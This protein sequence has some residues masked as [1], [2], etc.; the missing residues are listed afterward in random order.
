MG[1]GRFA[2][3]P[4]LPMMR[5]EGLL[6]VSDG[7]LIAS[8]HFLGYW[9]GAIIA[10]K[11]PLAP[12]TLLRATV[13]ICGVATLGMGLVEN[14][15]AI[16]GLRWVVGIC[17]AWVLVLVGNFIVRTLADAG[18]SD[19]QGIVFSGVGGGIALVGL[20]CLAFMVAG[21]DSVTSW[22]IAGMVSLVI[23]AVLCFALGPEFPLVRTKQTKRGDG[24]RP[25]IWPMLVSYGVAGMGYIIPATYLPLMAREMVSDP[26]I[27]GW[28]WPLFGAAAFASTLVAARFRKRY[29]D[30]SIWATCQL[31]MAMGI[32]LPVL[33][34]HIIGI[35]LSGLLVGGTFM[36]VTMAGVQEA[37]RVA[38]QADAIRHIAA[39]TT[40]FATGQMIGP[41]VAGSVYAVSKS[42]DAILIA[43]AAAVAATAALIVCFTSPKEPSCDETLSQ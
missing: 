42:F 23:A 10:A 16:A 39:M 2:Y 36:I 13:L 25:L 3:T 15:A 8:I 22:R 27:F 7:S 34:P 35:A 9:M 19:C 4:L 41:I 32:I 21:I 6:T 28:S 12:R 29:S 1:V 20:A 24:R 14:I 37:H 31:V 33:F 5:E 40:A 17:S 18:R 11:V 43:S 26:L 30:R 38:P